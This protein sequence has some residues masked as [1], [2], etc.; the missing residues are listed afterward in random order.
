MGNQIR[1]LIADDHNIFRSGVCQLLESK[2]DIIVVGEAKDGHEALRLAEIHRPDVVLMDI[3]MPGMDGMEATRSLKARWPE[4]EILVLTMHQ[5]D[6]YFFEMLTAGASGYILKGD[7]IGDLLNAI[8]I[9]HEGKVYLNPDMAQR[10]VQDFLNRTGAGDESSQ[11]LTKREKE[12]LGL[13]AEG[14]NNSEI[15]QRLV[16]SS[17]TVH[18]HRSNIMKKLNMSTRYELIQYARDQGLIRDF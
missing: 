9:V 4:I 18:S 17:S 2:A 16:I 3:A 13:L 1:V 5:Q 14:Y 15:A 11:M 8:Q 10:L 7:G 12:V 6:E